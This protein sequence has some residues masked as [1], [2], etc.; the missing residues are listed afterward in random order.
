[1]NIQRREEETAARSAAY[2]PTANEALD[3]ITET[4]DGARPDAA[5]PRPAV[6]PASVAQARVTD[7]TPA[8]AT[9]VPSSAPAAHVARSPQKGLRRRSIYLLPEER[10]LLHQEWLAR[11]ARSESKNQREV[12]YSLLVRE[13][14]RSYT[15]PAAAPPSADTA[16]DGKPPATREMAVLLGPE[17][18]KILF[19]VYRRRNKSERDWREGNR[20]AL[21]REAIRAHFGSAA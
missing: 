15:W 18:D 20:S 4:P 8:G 11:L 21:I 3:E 5:P 17:E 10:T 2:R 12:N 7:A 19:G 9:A 6:A 1:V 14:I 16:N 13:A